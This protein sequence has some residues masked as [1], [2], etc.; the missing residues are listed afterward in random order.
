MEGG[1]RTHD[2]QNYKLL[3]S[4]TFDYDPNVANMF[5]QSSH[6]Y[7]P[8]PLE[9]G[10]SSYAFFDGST[11]AD[12]DGSTDNNSAYNR[13]PFAEWGTYAITNNYVGYGDI[14]SNLVKRPTD[15]DLGGRNASGYFL[16][17]DAS[18][19]PGTIVTL[20]FTEN[21]CPGS[22]L[23]VSA[24]VK[25][26]DE[27]GDAIE[28]SAMLFTI[29]GVT[30]GGERVPLYRQ[31]TGQITTTTFLGTGDGS[32]Y[33]NANG[34][35]SQQN[36]WYQIYFSFLNKDERTDEFV[37]YELKVDN[38]CGSTAGGDF[39]L[40]EIKVYIAQ[41][42]ATVTQKDYA[43]TGER[44]LLRSSLDWYQLCE[45]IGLDP[46]ETDSSLEPKVSTSAS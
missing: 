16:Y 18:D 34:Y 21:L 29:Y 41:P 3:T 28:N 4:R 40:D 36:D 43:C 25:S 12:F 38:N 23:L 33:T 6:W 19:K 32:E 27:E 8:F 5:G 10:Y 35:G 7:Y 31:S 44:T 20:P 2:I 9:W 45:R 30:E 46:D 15:E 42:T 24:W 13:Q 22:E 14:V 37:S 26:A 1:A 17:V 11:T 39:Y